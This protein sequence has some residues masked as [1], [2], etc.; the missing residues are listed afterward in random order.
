[1][2]N[3]DRLKTEYLCYLMNRA[4]V[5]AEG[6]RGYLE[7]CRVMQDTN[8]LPILEMDDNRCED[9][10]ELRADYA[11]LYDDE[12]AADILDG[13][14]GETCTMMELTVVLAEKM[15]YNLEDSEYEAGT[16]KWFLEM[17]ENC[18]LTEYDNE[19]FEENEDSEDQVRTILTTL[20]FRKIGWDGE[21]SYFPLRW[22]KQDQ[23]YVELIIQMNNYIE[24]NYDIC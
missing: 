3:Y 22:P 24:E 2:R 13:L 7:L 4:Q 10:R 9:C 14:Y 1:M 21:G 19:Q 16:G 12:E 23:R 20:I 18:G 5:D 11:E 17:L 8:F 6:G 15:R